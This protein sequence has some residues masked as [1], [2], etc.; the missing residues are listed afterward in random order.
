M[1]NPV[2][3]GTRGSKLALYQAF[4]VKEELEAQFPAKNFEIV[5]IKT[6]GDKIL[7]VALSKIGDKGLFTKEL[8]VALFANE[9]DMA[10]H[11]LKD[12]PTTFPEG[13]KLGAVLKRGETRDAFVSVDDRKLHEM[14]P[15]DIVATSSLRRRAQLLRKYPNLKIVDIRG[16]VNTRIRKMQEGYCSA[17]VMA[18]A[19]L[20]RLDMGEHI[21]EVIDLDEMIPACGQ[22]AIAIEIKD[23]DPEI[24]NI[25]SAIN[26][27]VTLITT[28]AERAFLKTLEG[29]C[30]IPVG[31]HS[32]IEGDTFT[33]TG[34]ISSIDGLN[35]MKETAQGKI[36]DAE[37]LSIEI[38][39]KIYIRGGKQ[40]LDQVRTENITEQVESK[41]LQGKV[42]ITTRPID[43]DD[44]LPDLLKNEGA[45][46]LALPMIEIKSVT[47]TEKEKEALNKLIKFDWVFFTSKHGVVHFFKHLSEI[48]GNTNLPDSL[49]IGTVGKKT[50]AELDY[51][52][53]APDFISTGNTSTDMLD[54]FYKK[55]S[56]RN[57]NFLLALGNLAD[58][59]LENKLSEKNQVTRINIYKTMSPTSADETILK[60]IANN[61]YDLILLTSPSTFSNLKSF[62]DLKELKLA[63]IGQITSKAIQ[64][65][66]HSPLITAT[67]STTEGLCKAIIDY[68]STNQK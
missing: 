20:Q 17:M 68:Y 29:G 58:D 59:T 15:E 41:K 47:P 56:P 52:G 37:Q 51:Y 64:N 12:L 32:K 6:K 9:I 23:N 54:L 10:V 34:F 43:A 21:T 38:A 36:D 27:R 19:G 25:I 3:I 40:I 2:R 35:F 49:K 39:K 18:A 30:Q 13:T 60:R 14:T 65:E 16:N 67:T 53:Y 63:S 33:I 66:G 62:I 31:S 57:L 50:A 24:E 1:S 46:V 48:N 44:D 28:N 5:I 11:S 55:Y 26:D 45:E 22:G 8:E 7:D 42:L 61:S 4:R